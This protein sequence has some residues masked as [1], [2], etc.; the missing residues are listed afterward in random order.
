RERVELD[1]MREEIRQQLECI[2]RDA[3]L[4]ERLA[5]VERLKGE[6][7]ERQ[8]P[9]EANVGVS[10]PFARRKSGSSLT[11]WR[12]LLSG[13][14]RTQPTFRILKSLSV[15]HRARIGSQPPGSRWC[16]RTAL[17]S[18]PPLAEIA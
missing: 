5:A 16:G 13:S 1:R 9:P 7:V 2:Q 4:R 6:V 15:S 14:K 10:A 8:R 11:N 17:G 12:A 3:G 18:T